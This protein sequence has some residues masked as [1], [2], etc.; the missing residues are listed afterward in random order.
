MT[1]LHGR[2]NQLW[3]N[4]AAPGRLDEI[5]KISIPRSKTERQREWENF[6]LFSVFP[7]VPSLPVGLK[8]HLRESEHSIFWKLKVS[9]LKSLVSLSHIQ[10]QT[11]TQTHMNTCAFTHTYA[12]VTRTHAYTHNTNTYT[13][14]YTHAVRLIL[15]RVFLALEYRKHERHTERILKNTIL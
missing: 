2:R 15:T 10:A 14:T 13:R 7:S 5:A 3:N 11:Q 12:C 4:T 8:Q 1:V 9:P 6:V